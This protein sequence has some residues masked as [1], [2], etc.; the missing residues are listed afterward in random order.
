MASRHRLEIWGWGRSM[1]V[2]RLDFWGVKETQEGLE[3]RYWEDWGGIIAF[4]RLENFGRR[5]NKNICR[6]GDGRRSKDH[7]RF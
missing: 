4:W 6:P 5:M 3:A 7:W 2:W 1:E